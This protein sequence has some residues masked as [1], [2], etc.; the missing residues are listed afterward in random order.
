[1]TSTRNRTERDRESYESQLN[2]ETLMI[3]SVNYLKLVLVATLL[4]PALLMGQE[5]PDQAKEE[6]AIRE[7]GTE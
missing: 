7:V 6:A 2:W 3:R 1:M 4:I 5:V